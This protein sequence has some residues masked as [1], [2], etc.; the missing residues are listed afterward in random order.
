MGWAPFTPKDIEGSILKAMLLPYE[1][2]LVDC[3][4][5]SKLL[6]I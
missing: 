1:N 4:E 2:K 5:L 6:N 3:L